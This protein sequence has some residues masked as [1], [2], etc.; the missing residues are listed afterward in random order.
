MSILLRHTRTR[1]L[2]ARSLAFSYSY[3]NTHVELAIVINR[4]NIDRAASG[5]WICGGLE[6]YVEREL[7][8]V[9]LLELLAHLLHLGL[10]LVVRL[11]RLLERL[12]LVLRVALAFGQ[13]RGRRRQCA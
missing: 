10:Y 1:D 12:L 9:D 11:K 13:P 8:L 4:L 7:L 6:A 3:S 2:S 5:E